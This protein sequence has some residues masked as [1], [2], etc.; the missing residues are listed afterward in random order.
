MGTKEGL[1]MLCMLLSQKMVLAKLLIPL[2]PINR[3]WMV[4]MVVE[5]MNTRGRVY[6]NDSNIPNIVFI[7]EYGLG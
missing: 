1:P 6:G 3:E 5:K 2:I 7:V 4:F